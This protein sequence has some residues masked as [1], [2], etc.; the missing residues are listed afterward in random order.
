MNSIKLCFMQ[1]KKY[2]S[3]TLAIIILGVSIAFRSYSIPYY[4][5]DSN[6]WGYTYTADAMQHVYGTGGWAQADYSTSPNV[7]FSPSN[8]FVLLDGNCDNGAALDSFMLNNHV[9]IENWVTSGGRL[10]INSAPINASTVHFGFNNT[11]LTFGF[12]QTATALLPGDTIF[13]GPYTPVDTTYYGNYAS[14][15]TITGTGLT[16]LMRGDDTNHI[17]LAKEYWGAGC[18]YFG[19]LTPAEFWTQTNTG[20]NL[21]YNLIWNAALP[22]QPTATANSGS[23]ET[24]VTGDCSGTQMDVYMPVYAPGMSVKTYYGDNSSDSTLFNN[25]NPPCGHFSINHN[26]LASSNYTVKQ[27]LYDN[28]IPVDSLQFSYYYKFCNAA[29]VHFYYDANNNCLQDGTE[30]DMMYSSLIEVDSNNVPID[31]ISCTSGFYYTM[32]GNSGDTYKFR[33]ITLGGYYVSCPSNGVLSHT[34]AVANNSPE[35]VFGL[36]CSAGNNYDLSVTPVFISGRHKATAAFDLG[37][38][39]CTL[40]DA[41]VTLTYSPK[42]TFETAEPMPTSQSGQTLTWNFNNISSNTIPIKYI[43]ATLD[44]PAL[45]WLTPGD[46]V[47]YTLSVTPTTGDVNAVNNSAIIY[48]TITG[49]WDP[50][51][52]AV[53]PQGCVNAGTQLKYTT[54]FVNTGNAPAAN[55]Y[56][57]DTLPQELDV[58][59]LRVSAA[60]AKMYTTILHAGAY[61]I[62]RFEFPGINLPDSTHFPQNCSALFSYTVQAKTNLPYGANIANRAGIYFDDNDVVI[63]NYANNSICAPAEVKVDEAKDRLRI[64]PNP[65]NDVLTIDADE[66]VYRSFTVANT[67]GQTMIEQDIHNTQTTISVKLFP[68]GIYYIT[69][70]GSCGSEVRKFVK[71]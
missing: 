15:G 9:L 60:S 66:H 44:V 37:N 40:K 33:P 49:S 14:H 47:N 30:N 11:L 8:S 1:L 53:S 3:K 16:N 32:Y 36:S 17:I 38:S 48:D 19:S 59:T 35:L 20:K 31:T 61:N 27:V 57:L 41:V 13:H 56:V 45:P 54:E 63:T 6:P 68:A 4:V 52:I 5:V 55:I 58:N 10:F 62:L 23:F 46:T 39:Y 12:E 26:Y 69:L 64:Y 7:I 21:W 34:L 25:A 29:F 43:T 67:M 18:V 70:K 50:N 24:F 22:V 28:G 42:Y 51:H 65:A 2:I 71:L